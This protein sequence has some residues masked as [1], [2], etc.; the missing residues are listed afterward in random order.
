MRAML[1]K[2]C[3]DRRMKGHSD[4]LLAIPARRALRK[5]GEDLRD[6]RRRRRIP[7]AL[8]AERAQISRTTLTKVE[9]GDPAV[10]LGIYAAVLFSLGLIDRLATLADPGLDAVG[11][12]LE[13]EQLP[14]RIVLKRSRSGAVERGLR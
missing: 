9:Q 3:S 6:A 8:L 5:L 10:S 2:Q 4:R 1:N 12:Q 13:Q 7:M 11:L 14:Q